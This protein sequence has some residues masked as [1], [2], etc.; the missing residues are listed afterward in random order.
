MRTI[1][2]MKQEIEEIK[3]RIGHEEMKKAIEGRLRKR[4]Q[5]L[6]TCILYM[7]TNPDQE[8][9]SA[10]IKMVEGKINRRME[11]FNE[12]DYK[13]WA[14]KDVAKVRKAYEK[15]YD[16]PKLRSQVSAMRFILK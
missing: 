12:D 16:I 14:K 3:H 7:E 13:E 11:G 8:F 6:N 15:E 10:Q 4:I 1:K 5:F 2:E 9:V